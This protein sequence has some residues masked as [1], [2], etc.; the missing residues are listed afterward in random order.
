[1][2]V[3]CALRYGLHYIPVLDDLAVLQAEDVRYRRAAIFKWGLKQAVG[4]DQVALGDGALDVEAQLGELLNKALYELDESLEAI[5]SLG[6]VLYVVRAA[7]V[8]SASAGCLSLNAV[9][10]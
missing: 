1:V 4:H 10:R 9:L 7:V 2:V 5:G 8:L 3:R 6:V